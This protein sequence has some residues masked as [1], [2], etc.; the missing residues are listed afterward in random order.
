ME[1]GRSSAPS[2]RRKEPKAYPGGELKGE[3]RRPSRGGEGGN[4]KNV[5]SSARGGKVVDYQQRVKSIVRLIFLLQWGERR[6][7]N[8]AGAEKKGTLT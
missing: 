8:E 4:G 5:A 6:K 1:K 7:K 3:G 2:S